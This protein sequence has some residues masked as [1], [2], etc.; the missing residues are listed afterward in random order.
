MVHGERN[1]MRDRQR[2]GTARVRRGQAQ[3]RDSGNAS[4][5]GQRRDRKH[6]PHTTPGASTNLGLEQGAPD[7][8][9]VGSRATVGA[10]P[11]VSRE[12]AAA[13]HELP[14]IGD[15]HLVARSIACHDRYSFNNRS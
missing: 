2:R 6:P 15:E 14:E 11:Q 12:I 3:N 4:G 7:D 9:H 1:V 5:N 10:R 13:A 8:D